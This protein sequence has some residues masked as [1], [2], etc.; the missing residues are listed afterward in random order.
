MSTRNIALASVSGAAL[1]TG[2]A[3]SEKEMAETALEQARGNNRAA[4]D[5][6]RAS[7][8]ADIDGIVAAGLQ[9]E[10]K[11]QHGAFILGRM[12]DND[13]F[14]DAADGKD[15]GRLCRD[16][17]KNGKP[18]FICESLFGA[19]PDGNTDAAKDALAKWKNKYQAVQD[20][21]KI[22]RVM[23]KNGGIWQ[24]DKGAF[25]V[26][27]AAIFP[28]GS[29]VLPEFQQA[30]YPLTNKNMSVVVPD[31]EGGTTTQDVRMNWSNV[32]KQVKA[33]EDA[34]SGKNNARGTKTDNGAAVQFNAKTFDFLAGRFASTDK[35]FKDGSD[36]ASAFENML[37]TLAYYH[38]DLI[39]RASDMAENMRKAGEQPKA[40]V[41]EARPAP[42]EEPAKPNTVDA[43]APLAEQPDL[44]PAE[45]PKANKRSKRRAKAK[46]A[47]VRAKSKRAK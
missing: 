15:H 13:E 39:V 10:R 26:P 42:A 44:S 7:L 14:I 36:I 2:R 35:L 47:R 6:D 38:A 27:H 46:A 30:L 19:R 21:I 9:I 25:A 41:V 28:A 33:N 34:A 24:A 4:S 3:P 11:Q 1:R 20:I 22:C 45:Q 32:K 16:G 29:A 5:A 18:V 31:G 12:I 8:I 37:V 17:D 43:V 23:H 40:R